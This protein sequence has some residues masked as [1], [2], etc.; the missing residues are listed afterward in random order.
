MH[1]K[2]FAYILIL[3]CAAPPVFA[4]SG[5]EPALRHFIQEQLLRKAGR[6]KKPDFNEFCP[7]DSNAV[8]ARVFQ[9][10]GSMFAADGSVELPRVCMFA[11]DAEVTKFQRSLDTKKS[12]IGAFEIELQEAAMEALLDAVAE[13]ES[14]GL[15]IT[16]LDGTIAGRRSFA[17]T[18][19]LWNS[20]FKPALEHWVARGRISRSD[21][22]AA[23]RMASPE[24][25]LKV[26]DWESRGLYFSTGKNRPIMSSVAPPGTS[27]HL[28]LL[29]FDV[30]QSG[31]RRVREIMNRNGWYQTVV[32]DPPHFTFIGIE[33]KKLPERGLKPHPVG[34]YVYWVP[35]RETPRPTRPASVPSPR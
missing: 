6:G 2:Y 28:S 15:K 17:D 18:S 31:D 20:R 4:Q 35:R 5:D 7:V 33:E 22:D 11:S 34:S 29:A 24:Q 25:T 16:P 1:F 26:L 13:A 14:R 10:Y 27:Q 3:A 30:E 9:E 8:A 19:R 21:A 32:G 12:R 23:L